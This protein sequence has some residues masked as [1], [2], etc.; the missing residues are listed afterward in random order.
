MVNER[1]GPINHITLEKKCFVLPSALKAFLL[2]FL[3]LDILFLF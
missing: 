3:N 2:W 1:K